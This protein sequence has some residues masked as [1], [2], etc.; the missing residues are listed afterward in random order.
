MAD[1]NGLLPPGNMGIITLSGD[2]TASASGGSLPVT[3]TRAQS[4]A[5]VFN[6]DGSCSWAVASNASIA[7]LSTSTATQG[8]NLVLQP[9]GSAQA[10]NQG[11][12]NLVVSLQAPLGT[13]TE[14]L[15]QFQRG[16]SNR[17][18]F[19][20]DPIAPAYGG[21][22]MGNVTPSAVN[23]AILSD[24][25]TQLAINAIGLLNLESSTVVQLSFINF[26]RT[27]RRIAFR[28]IYRSR[29]WWRCTR[30]ISGD[31]QPVV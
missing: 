28:L 29:R 18:Q 17:I 25:A 19:G 1:V 14:A 8:A 26:W 11:G 31:N 12:G 13:G 5:L 6:S 10:T 22:W 20:A 27:D 30:N 7:Q 23:F 4:G 2:A 24:G 15:V 9:Q 21:F 3:I 16:G